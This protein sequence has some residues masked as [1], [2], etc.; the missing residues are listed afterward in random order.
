MAALHA[1]PT[2][3][4]RRRHPE[5]PFRITARVLVCGPEFELVY[6]QTENGTRYVLTPN[7][8]GVRL[9]DFREGQTD[10]C[11]IPAGPSRV[12]SAALADAERVSEP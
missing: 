12:L 5:T 3:S 7:T 11:L 2:R 10:E 9:E 8:A 1:L 4:G 6:V